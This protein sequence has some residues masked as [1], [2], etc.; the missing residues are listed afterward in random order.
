MKKILFIPLTM[1]LAT[2]NCVAQMSPPTQQV[3]TNHPTNNNLPDSN[4]ITFSEYPPDTVVTTQYLNEG[5]VFSGFNGS[6]PPVIY[7]YGSSSF[8]SILHSDTW[9]SPFRVDFVDPANPS[10]YQLASKI[11]FDN[12]INSTSETDY[13]NIDVYDSN[14]I[15]LRNYLSTSFEHVIID[16]GVASAAYMT[17]DDSNGTAF[18]FDNLL[19]TFDNLATQQNSAQDYTVLPNPCAEALKI[20]AP[21][22]EATEIS[23]YSLTGTRLL[24]QSFTQTTTINTA[25][26]PAGMYLYTMTNK[27][28]GVKTGKIV[29]Y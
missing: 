9:Y 6:S 20:T 7:D 24:T 8:G 4:S 18:I 5:V 29:K 15:L 25:S 3:N 27:S 16:L 14:G 12:A 23:F 26:L 19:V 1:M 2:I 22:N 11:E 17:I 28:G 21:L 10:Q 13:M